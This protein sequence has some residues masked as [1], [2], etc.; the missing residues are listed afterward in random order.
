MRTGRNRWWGIVATAGALG[1]GV[2]ALAVAVGL[3]LA[4]AGPL[5]AEGPAPAPAQ[6]PVNKP[7]KKPAP[8]KAYDVLRY[9]EDWSALRDKPV[10][11][12]CDLADRLKA[13]RLGGC[14]WLDLGGQVRLRYESFENFNLQPAP[15]ADDDWLLTRVRLHANLVLGRHLR[16][17]AEGIFAD[18][19]ERELGPRPVD[20]NDPDLLNLFVEGMTPLACGTAGLRVGRQELLFDRQRLVGPLD[21][22]NTRRTF[23]GVLAWWKDARWRVDAFYVQ[24]VLVDADDLDEADDATDFAGVH[25][26]LTP[27]KGVTCAAFAYYLRRDAATYLGVTDEEQRFTLGVYAAGPIPRTA[28]DYDLEAAYQAGTFGD[29]DIS[30]WMVSAELGW[31]PC[32]RC[33][34]PRLALGFDY[35]SGDDDG[36]G[37][38]LGTFQQLFPTG[39]LWFGWVDLIGRQNVLAGRVTA[40]LKPL[41][42]LTLRADYHVIARAEEADAAYNAAGGVLRAPLGSDATDVLREVDL[43]LTWQASRSLVVEGGGGRAFAGD[44]LEATG[45][46]EDVD[47]LYLSTT[48]TF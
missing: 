7:V 21:W 18:Q 10:G 15:A 43:V 44:F 16:L 14:A 38:D 17:F 27:R 22:G 35:A 12:R 34:E 46:S 37:G 26:T 39:H 31:K 42:K 3:G 20:E 11:A 48:F 9:R 13:L 5:R 28:L 23:E 19:E 4:G 29:G 33:F 6:A 1:R 2:A 45:A 24:P 41:P 36:P 30:A 32:V 40:T 47:F 8:P 25:A